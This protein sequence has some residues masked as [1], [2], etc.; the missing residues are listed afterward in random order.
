MKITLPNG[1]VVESEETVTI[2]G[3]TIEPGSYVRKSESVLVR[4]TPEDEGPEEE[5][6]DEE[7]NVNE[8]G[9]PIPPTPQPSEEEARL[10]AEKAV[11]NHDLE[12]AEANL[13]WRHRDTLH[14]L[15][16]YNGNGVHYSFV[17]EQ[18][19]ISGAAANERC[20]Q[21]LRKGL[22]ERVRA[23]T[24]RAVRYY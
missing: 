14:L 23:G 22:A 10:E 9:V 5:Y 20:R 17:A 11:R 2:G 18:F 4:A 13:S 15:R 7:P 3:I 1:V 19:E 21:L 16:N 6:E 12:T 8:H 24:Y